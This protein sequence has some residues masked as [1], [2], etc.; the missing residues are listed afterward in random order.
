MRM[1]SEPLQPHSWAGGEGFSTPARP[2]TP[3]T[4]PARSRGHARHWLIAGM[5]AL[6]LWSS[7]SILSASSA[8]LFNARGLASLQR[9]WI[10]ALSPELSPDFLVRT[11]DAAAVTLAFSVLGALLASAIGFVGG[12]A[13]SASFHT[14]LIT[15]ARSRTLAGAR[16]LVA[17]LTW[18]LPRGVHESI[19]AIG[20]LLVLG[21]DPLVGI[22]A[23]GIPFGAITVKVWADILDNTDQ[24]PAQALRAAGAHRVSAIMYATVPQ[25]WNDFVSYAF[26]R[27]DC[28]LRSAV[29][30]GMLGVG[31]IGFELLTAFQ[32]LNYERM[33]TQLYALIVLGIIFERWSTLL[34]LRPSALASR[35]SVVLITLLALSSLWYLRDQFRLSPLATLRERVARLWEQ[36]IPPSLPSTAGQLVRD[37]VL[38]LQISVLAIAI[39]TAFG[40]VAAFASAAP[41]GSSVPRRALGWGADAWLLL[42]RVISVPV[43][44]LLLLFIIFPGPLPGALAL[45]LYNAGVLGRLF[46]EAIHTHDQRPALALTHLGASG[47]QRF[48]YATLPGLSGRFSD[49]ALYRWEVAIRETVVVGVVGAGGLGRVLESERASF[50]YSAMLTVV[51]CLIVL[52]ALVDALSS[53]TRRILSH[54]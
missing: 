8:P 16:H 24:R 17:R 46:A 13:M 34:R 40:L 42:A 54:R 9:F 1:N 19:W 10:A 32:G 27:L 37:S 4:A 12:I 39:A 28:A 43:W 23:L 11:L 21:R 30:L 49:Y 36:A 18:S 52:S 47:C 33:W 53:L 29:I 14:R 35:I 38:T 2:H 26:Y 44:A 6:L 45:G 50:D 51:V 22:L 41:P 5:G 48:V 15:T 20:F 3:G 31:G 25:A 7:V